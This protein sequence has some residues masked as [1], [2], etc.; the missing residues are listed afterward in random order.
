MIMGANREICDNPVAE[1]IKLDDDET[2]MVHGTWY[3]VHGTWYDDIWYKTNLQ[4]KN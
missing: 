1:S 4:S 3:M 2:M